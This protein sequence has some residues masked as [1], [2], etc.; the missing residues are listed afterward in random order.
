M[1][2]LFRHPSVKDVLSILLV[3]GQAD[4]PLLRMAIN[5]AFQNKKL[6]TPKDAGLAVMKGA[7][8]YGLESKTMSG[9]V[10]RNTNGVRA[11]I[12]FDGATHA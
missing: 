2:Q 8:L 11:S 12:L 7:V 3:L 10:C 9:R 6:I 4:S 5:K 1:Q